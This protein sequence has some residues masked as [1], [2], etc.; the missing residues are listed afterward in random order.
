MKYSKF[1]EKLSLFIAAAT[2]LV[3][4]K[5]VFQKGSSPI[6]EAALKKDFRIYQ[7]RP[8]DTAFTDEIR[9]Y[10]RSN[11]EALRLSQKVIAV[12]QCLRIS[13]YMFAALIAKESSFNP[14][15]ISPTFARGLTQFTTIAVKEFAFKNASLYLPKLNFPLAS[16]IAFLQECSFDLLPSIRLNNLAAIVSGLLS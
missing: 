16:T 2:L 11:E 5:Y 7:K 3:I 15:A 12:S 10:G 13:P 1:L 4:C 8:K 9:R 14:D 6:S